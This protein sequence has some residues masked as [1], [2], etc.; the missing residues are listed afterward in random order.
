MVLIECTS[1]IW[2]II[3]LEIVERMIHIGEV[4][5]IWTITIL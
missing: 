2:I 3:T 1:W 5:Q 4:M